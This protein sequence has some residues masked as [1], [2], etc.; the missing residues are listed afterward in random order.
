VS[1]SSLFTRDDATASVTRL[2]GP[3]LLSISL[4]TIEPHGAE[5]LL[6]SLNGR[7]LD[8]MKSQRVFLKCLALEIA[9][10]LSAI[11]RQSLQ[12]GELPI[13][14]KKA[15]LT[16]VFKKGG[17]QTLPTIVLCH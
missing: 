15:W 17:R 4:L 6:S 14:W 10:A 16:P 3:D 5:K 1:S 7:L 9:Q 13:P 8:L 11:S 12:T 2:P